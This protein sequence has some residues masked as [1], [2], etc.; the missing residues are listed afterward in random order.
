RRLPDYMVPTAWVELDALPLNA[1]G[2]VD[3]KALRLPD[4]EQWLLAGECVDARTP[5]EAKLLALWRETLALERIGVHDDFFDLGG[6]SLLATRL[7]GRIAQE[8][9]KEVSLRMLFDASTPARLAERL[10]DTDP[11]PA[12]SDAI[13]RGACD[14]QAAS[15][16]Q[17]RLWFID[18]YQPGTS[19]YNIAAAWRL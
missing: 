19:L 13:V 1:N 15:F 18:Q 12:W 3:R 9:G 2:K 11:S 6:H 16:A 8:L 10:G 14:G 17:R 7:T 5:L 4:R